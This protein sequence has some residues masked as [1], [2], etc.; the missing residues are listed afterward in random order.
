MASIGQAARNAFQRLARSFA[1][2]ARLGRD[3]S[4]QR[5]GRDG[6]GRSVRAVSVG[7]AG[8]AD[9]SAAGAHPTQPNGLRGSEP[10]QART[11]TNGAQLGAQWSA[12]ALKDAFIDPKVA[13]RYMD[14]VEFDGVGKV[15]GFKADLSSAE[16]EELNRA[17]VVDPRVPINPVP[18][19]VSRALAAMRSAM[20]SMV[21]MSIDPAVASRFMDQ[22][23]FDGFGRIQGFKQGLSTDDLDDLRQAQMPALTQTNARA[24]R[25]TPRTEAEC[26]M[27]FMHLMS[28]IDARH[29][30]PLLSEAQAM[31]QGGR[32]DRASLTGFFS[33]AANDLDD[34]PGASQ[35]ALR[36]KEDV[37]T[38]K[39]L[40]QYVDSVLG[41]KFDSEFAHSLVKDPPPAL[42]ENAQ[43]LG[44]AV[45][46][47]LEKV[48]ATRTDLDTDR[49]LRRLARYLKADPRPWHGET[50]EVASF[51]SEPTTANLRRVLTKVD[52]G[53]DVIKVP[54][55]LTK[56]SIAA[57]DP[58]DPE[59][60]KTIAPWMDAADTNYGE[61]ILPT[62]TR[63]ESPQR[64]YVRTD[65][66]PK[67]L[68]RA[69]PT[70]DSGTRLQYHPH[71]ETYPTFVE[72]KSVADRHM[73]EMSNLTTAET[74]AVQHGQT[75]VSGNSGTTNIMTFLADHFAGRHSPSAPQTPSISRDQAY[76]STLMFVVFD[77]GHSANESVSVY[78]SIREQPTIVGRQHAMDSY[79]LDYGDLL[80]IGERAGVRDSVQ[81]AIDN[82]M[83][84]TDAFFDEFAT[85]A[86]EN[87]EIATGA[88][89]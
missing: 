61:A 26:M 57:R 56:F 23:R 60:V 81:G 27:Q 33:K 65:R 38:E 48:K 21:G 55:I 86:R 19:R 74:R 17:R 77:G 39:P 51:L 31:W 68:E 6:S 66:E 85:S 37:G 46:G 1:D 25:D 44:A 36:L 71:N 79:S 89:R 49:V 42:L 43:R 54:W 24:P 64:L 87:Q 63:R 8:Q 32:L 30:K 53:F 20:D 82:A 69:I 47:H 14:R 10:G 16:V 34:H 73:P 67:S 52:S 29:A 40:N 84:K 4:V 76:L 35:L 18:E 70:R 9:N 13:T 28:R 5:N 83:S 80:R 59:C 22:V 72:G 41:R 58:L 2:G 12:R 50:P 7:V 3:P 75:L 15:V 62:R 88:R 11:A 78:K 45:V